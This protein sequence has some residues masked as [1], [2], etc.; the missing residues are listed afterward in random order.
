MKKALSP[1]VFATKS[2]LFFFIFTVSTHVFGQASL[3]VQGVLVKSDG[4]AVDDGE[5]PIT[6]KLWTA[7]NGGIEKHTETISDVETSGG[8]YSVVLGKNGTPLNAAFDQV[9]YLGVSIA[10]G[11]ELTPRPLLT[12]APYALSLLG[13]NNTFPSTGM[14][15][16]DGIKADG[17]VP[18]AGK[19]YSFDA[20]GDQDGGLFSNGDGQVSI[21]AD[22]IQKVKV[23]PAL[24]EI[25]GNLNTNNL[26]AVGYSRASTGFTQVGDDATGI[27]FGTQDVEIRSANSTGARITVNG[28]GANYYNATSHAFGG[29][30]LNISYGMNVDGNV[31]LY[32]LPDLGPGNNVVSWDP[33]NKQLGYRPSTSSRRYKTNIQPLN[34]DFKL[35]LKSQPKTYSRPGFPDRF[36]IGYIAEEM[37]SIGL[38]KLVIYNKDGIVD[39]FEYEKM[40]VY[41]VEVLKMQDA[42]ISKLKNEVAVLQAEK[43][44]SDAQNA[45]LKTENTDLKKMQSAFETQLSEL[46]RRMKLLENG[47]G[48]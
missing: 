11:T 13:Q 30:N 6:F 40:I 36:E 38:K 48:K 17:G 19:G 21:Y 43:T 25:F 24:T 9:Y 45:N 28:D 41:A 27:F 44:N 15:L 7:L 1:I 23:T 47:A 16:A 20:A 46:A 29:G 8:V 35:I 34:D 39:A 4:T 14:V 10:G 31:F 32:G 33:V 12:H 42:A 22:N 5:Y 2:L 26:N 18:T 37:D 3:S